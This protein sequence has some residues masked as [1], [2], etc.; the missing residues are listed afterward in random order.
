MVG[1]TLVAVVLTGIVAL[2]V[3]TGFI[4]TWQ[5]HRGVRVITCP[6][7]HEAAA[8]RVSAIDAARSFALRH[9]PDLHLKACSRWPEMEGC[10]EACRKEIVADPQA[11]SV[12]S[13]VATWY[14]GR[15]CHFCRKEIGEIVWHERPPAVMLPDGTIHEW[16]E[17]APERLPAIFQSGAAVCWPCFLVETFRAEYPELVVGRAHPPAVI[18][19][20]IGP[21]TSLY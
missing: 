14:Q 5:I 18:R 2:L 3:G 7:N 13:I 1:W 16:K 12:R 17:L 11:C 6:E 21:S 20:T 4:R 10:D 15:H 19:H 8:V 9:R